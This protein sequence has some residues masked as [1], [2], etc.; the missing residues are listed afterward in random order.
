[1]FLSKEFCDWESPDLTRDTA[2]KSSPVLRPHSWTWQ[3][4]HFRFEHLTRRS[5]IKSFGDRDLKF[6]NPGVPICYPMKTQIPHWRTNE[7]TSIPT[8]R[9]AVSTSEARI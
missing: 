1:L 8:G 2:N 6:V 7:R 9:I 5:E 3:N 4:P